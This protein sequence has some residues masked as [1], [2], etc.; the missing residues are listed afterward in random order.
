MKGSEKA[1]LYEFKY[2]AR[3]TN[4]TKIIQI[5]SIEANTYQEAKRRFEIAKEF[6]ANCEDTRVKLIEDWMLWE[7]WT[8]YVGCEKCALHGKDAP[9]WGVAGCHG[10][11]DGCGC[12]SCMDKEKKGITPPYYSPTLRQWI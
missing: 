3:R 4:H 2:E 10:F 6:I 1:M 12:E 9:C 7:G 8:E 11:Y 5:I